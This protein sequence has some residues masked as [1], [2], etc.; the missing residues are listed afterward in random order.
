[1]P[2]AIGPDRRRAPDSGMEKPHTVSARKRREA[3]QE[4]QPDTCASTKTREQRTRF[5][6]ELQDYQARTAD[7]HT[8]A[9]Q[10]ALVYTYRHACPLSYRSPLSSATTK[11]RGVGGIHLIS[12]FPAF[13]RR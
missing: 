7:T 12:K 4:A 13:P 9:H 11:R 5:G 2:G 8:H 10:A 1:M 6:Y 3:W